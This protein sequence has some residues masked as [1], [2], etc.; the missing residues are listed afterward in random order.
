VLEEEARRWRQQLGIAP[1]RCVLLFAGKFS[2]SKRPIELMRAVLASTDRRL[3]LVMVG[4]GELDAEVK[5]LPA[6]D[7]DRFRVLPSRIKAVCLRC[8]DSVIYL[9]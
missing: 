1:D 6:A 7:P 9:S 5:L 2:S 4:S 3:Q 8:T